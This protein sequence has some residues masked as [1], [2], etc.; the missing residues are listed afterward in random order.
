MERILKQPNRK[1]EGTDKKGTNMNKPVEF[2]KHTDP[3]FSKGQGEEP[4]KKVKKDE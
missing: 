1:F 3:S 2:E 4:R